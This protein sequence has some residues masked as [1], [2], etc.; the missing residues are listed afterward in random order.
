M[1][2]IFVA[3]HKKGD[4]N[5]RRGFAVYKVVKLLAEQPQQVYRTR[6]IADLT[7]VSM[8][9]LTLAL[10]TLIWNDLC[11]QVFFDSSPLFFEG[12]LS[13]RRLRRRISLISVHWSDRAEP[14]PTGKWFV[15]S[16]AFYARESDGGGRRSQRVQHRWLVSCLRRKAAVMSLTKSTHRIGPG[17]VLGDLLCQGFSQAPGDGSRWSIAQR[18]PTNSRATAINAFCTGLPRSVRCLYRWYSRNAARSA[19][20][21]AQAGWS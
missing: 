12:G 10:C 3:P 6:G 7:G 19:K 11:Q 16:P 14:E 5:T 1:L 13:C 18:N 20:S 2:K 9:I 17:Q 15:E 4:A 8:G 21:M